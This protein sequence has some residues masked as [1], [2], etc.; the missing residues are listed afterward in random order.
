[1]K[2]RGSGILLHITSLPSPF[3]IGDL[4]PG[5]YQF[6]DF[7]VET[8]QSYWQILPLNPTSSVLG[9]SPYNSPSAFAGNPL[10]ISPELLVERGFLSE[11]ELVTNSLFRSERVDY[12]N[13]TNYKEDILRI[14]Y[15]NNKNQLR[16][17]NAFKR[18]CED[19]S[20]WLEDYALFVSLKES[21]KNVVWREWP[22]E[23]RDRSDGPLRE[24]RERL[25]DR[26]S[27]E[28]FYQY[29]FFDQ[30]SSLKEYCN[31]RKISVIGDVPIY[32]TF[33]SS[34]VWTNPEIFK[35]D[36]QKRPEFV[37]GVP[38]D[39]FSET[40]QLWGNPVYNWDY[41]RETRY[42]WW[43]KRLE[44]NIKLTDIIRL[45][46]FRGFVS[47]WEVPAGE[48]TAINGRWVEVPV[49]DYFRS[50]F[51]RF[52]NLPVIAED[53]GIITPDVREVMNYFDFPGMKLLIFAF[54]DD[55]PNGAYLPHNYLGNCVVYT[56]THDNNTVKGWFRTE[57]SPQDKKRLFSY[58]GREVEEEDIH[59]ELI[60]LAMSSVANTVIIPMQDILGLGE[61]SKMNLP[62]TSNGNWQWRLDPKQ[63]TS[64]VSEKLREITE[65][66]GRV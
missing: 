30:W 22:E 23:I 57:A 35:L 51:K 7:L 15:E 42:S 18:F 54:G 60:R 41:L 61:E 27:M 64:L 13:V 4:G 43:I 29:L 3:G 34:D 52:P 33:D 28:R 40:G 46:H 63:I 56:G 55:F 11:S 6:V 32:V 65:T 1:M 24:Y 58:I 62:A 8:K 49:V 16:T 9:N 38:P 37:A 53:L 66:Y 31:V 39:Y 44:H 50:L 26:I 2:C 48:E 47:Y 5:A 12:E 14:A 19:S 10:L 45:D 25:E 36:G 20:S 21:F 59:W 17:D